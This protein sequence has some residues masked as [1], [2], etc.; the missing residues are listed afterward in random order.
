VASALGLSFTPRQPSS[1]GYFSGSGAPQPTRT[2]PPGKLP[3]NRLPDA[4]ELRRSV[5]G[6]RIPPFR[7][8]SMHRW[9]QLRP[10]THLFSGQSWHSH[11]STTPDSAFSRPSLRASRKASHRSAAV[12]SL[13]G[14]H[15]R[16]SR[17]LRALPSGCVGD[18]SDLSMLC[19]STP[20]TNNN[21]TRTQM[22]V[23]CVLE[24]Q[25]DIAACVAWNQDRDSGQVK[26]H[27]RVSYADD[28]PAG[29]FENFKYV[30][31]AS[32]I[33]NMTVDAADFYS[34]G[35]CGFGVAFR[36]C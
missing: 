2:L 26:S 28:C 8:S 10:C 7:L 29:S 36:S 11:S 21:E 15:S 9:H 20:G 27:P 17:R 6:H 35:G 18:L 23:R 13:T 33:H 12:H 30:W 4:Q 34:C 25:R 1:K 5:A 22:R 16:I 14:L 3:L 19:A 31:L 24:A 32:N